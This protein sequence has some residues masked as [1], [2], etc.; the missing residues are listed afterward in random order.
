MAQNYVKIPKDLSLI[1]QKFI[2]GLTKRQAISFGIGAVMGFT[3]FY[4]CNT[5]INFQAA[6]FA[7][8]ICAFPA[9]FCGIFNKNGMHFE[10]IIKLM[11]AFF[12]KPRTRTYQSENTFLI[13]SRQFEY[14]KLKQMLAN[15]DNKRR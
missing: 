6:C 5:T 1:K 12:R 9:I 14:D 11:I 13:L 4:I 2:L 10:Q 7:L 3:A 15:S 8:G